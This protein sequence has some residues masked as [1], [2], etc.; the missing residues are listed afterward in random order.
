MLAGSDRISRPWQGAFIACVFIALTVAETI[1]ALRRQR[2]A[3][4]LHVA[5]NLGVAAFA[6]V[7]MNV[8]EE[9]LVAQLTRHRQFELLWAVVGI[10]L[11]DY[12]L[13]IWHVLTHRV[14]FLWRFHLPHHV[15]LDLDA[16]TA[17]RFHFGEM[18]LAVP[19]RALQVTLLGIDYRTYS[20][21]QTILFVSIL[22]HHSNLRLPPV[23]ERRLAWIVMTP[24]LHAIHHDANYAH[25]NSN[26]SSGLSVWDRLHGTFKDDVP[27]DEVSV[28]VPGYTGQDSLRHVLSMPF[29]KVES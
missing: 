26:W 10:L 22:F 14:P 7:V 4:P 27:Q 13:Y 16:S 21:W 11:L 2:E 17:L 12:T 19:Y 23:V 3:K 8:L 15:D 24:R 9:P 1:R 6:G 28:G 18:L 5:R 20:I 29:H 25:L